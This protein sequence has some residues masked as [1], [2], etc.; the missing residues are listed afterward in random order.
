MRHDRRDCPVLYP[1]AASEVRQVRW[2]A[3]RS[4]PQGQDV[5]PGQARVVEVRDIAEDA[6]D[7]DRLHV[8]RLGR[9]EELAHAIDAAPE[10]E[11]RGRGMRRPLPAPLPPRVGRHQNVVDHQVGVDV[12]AHQSI[13]VDVARGDPRRGGEGGE[14]DPD[15]RV[16]EPLS[17][18]GSDHR[19]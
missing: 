15:L 11:V 10:E 7:G 17:T 3:V 6:A 8:D 1:G 18:L 9:L 4:E 19:E 12:V 13:L 16:L 5:A 14:M 2:P